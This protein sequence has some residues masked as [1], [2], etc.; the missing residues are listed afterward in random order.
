MSTQYKRIFLVLFAITAIVCLLSKCISENNTTQKNSPVFEDYAGSEKCASCHKDIYDQY[1]KTAHHFTSMPA[2][3][4][5][6]KGSFDKGKNILLYTELLKVAMEKRD[7]GLYQTIY[8]KEQEK[9]AMQFDMVIGSGKIGQS[10]ITNRQ[11]SFYQLPVSYFTA[12]GQWANSPGFMS[13]RILTDRLITAR[14]LECHATYAAGMGG[15]AMEPKGFDTNKMILG[16]GCENCH[17][18]SAQH[19][20]YHTKN[21]EEKKAKFVV[22]PAALSRQ[23]QLDACALCHAGKLQKTR[24]SFGFTVGKNLAQYFRKNTGFKPIIASDEAEVHGDQYGLLQESKCFKNSSVMTCNT[25]HNTHENERGNLALFSTRC[26]SCHN[27]NTENFKNSSTHK[28][29]KSIA[30]NCINCHMP[31]QSSK[32]I[33]I[34]M[35]GEDTA[36]ASVLRSHFIGIYSAEMI[37]NK[38]NKKKEKR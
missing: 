9:M 21:P 32:A 27:T 15:T 1:A 2:E 13:N 34:Y 11:N 37:Q 18:P 3:E 8:Y 22:N 25:C 17:G 38:Q 6:I 12:A 5:N 24:P 20:E 35:E 29:V 4:K 23:H 10:Y 7:S 36:R 14:C 19:I 26:I 28:G 16:V 33:A 31:M 30:T